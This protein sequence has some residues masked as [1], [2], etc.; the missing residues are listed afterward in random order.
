MFASVEA[1]IEA[2]L[3][4]AFPANAPDGVKSDYHELEAMLPRAL[5]RLGRTIAAGPKWQQT[6]RELRLPVRTGRTTLRFDTWQADRVTISGATLTGQ[7]GSYAVAVQTLPAD[8]SNLVASN[9]L[10]FT[11]GVNAKEQRLALYPLSV[12]YGEDLGGIALAPLSVTIKTDNTLHAHNYST[13]I[14]SA[15]GIGTVTAGQKVR[16]VF[17][18]DGTIKVQRRGTDGALLTEND[19]PGGQT[20]LPLTGCHMIVTQFV[21]DGGQW[22]NG[23]IQ[24]TGEYVAELP[25]EAGVMLDGLRNRG[26]VR[27]ECNGRTLGLQ[28]AVAAGR[29][30][31]VS[32]LWYWTPVAAADGIGTG[33]HVWHPGAET[34]PGAFV[35][36]LANVVPHWSWLPDEFNNDLISTL[37]ELARERIGDP[38]R[39]QR[40]QRI[41]PR[42]PKQTEGA[43]AA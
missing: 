43:E 1:V 41:A 16:V 20:D 38:A 4:Q 28:E 9:F 23:A 22:I 6:R 33:L 14:F 3:I 11:R 12:P 8:S 24:G 21:T 40:E 13:P 7:P 25:A 32:G 2:T 27:W 19:V 18:A 37:V 17:N 31:C 39:K 29:V 30:P 10:E 26:Q 15:G 34:L 36:V 5:E 42:V 35:R